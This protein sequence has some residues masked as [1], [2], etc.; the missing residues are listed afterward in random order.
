MHSVLHLQAN[1]SDAKEDQ[2]LEETL[3]ET[4]LGS[5][6]AH[7]HGA[8]L[9]MVPNENDL[10]GAHHDRDETLRLCGLGGLVAENLLKSEVLEAGV[11]SADASCAN[12]VG[13]LKKFALRGILKLLELLLVDVRK[14]SKLFFERDQLLKLLMIW[15]VEVPNLVVES[16][17]VYP[18][19]D[20]LPTLGAQTNHLQAS[21][22]E[23]L[24][25]LIDRDVRRGADQDLAL[26]LPR[27][28]VHDGRARHRFSSAGRPLDEV[29]RALHGLLDGV[30]LGVI[31]LG[32]VGSR[33]MPRKCRS[34]CLSLHIMTQQSVV[35]ETGDARVIDGERPHGSL[36]T[37]EGGRFPDELDTEAVAHVPRTDV[38]GATKLQSDLLVRCDLGD[39]TN[40]APACIFGIAEIGVG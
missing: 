2:T 28:V 36:H 26:I 38:L 32:Q 5:S 37:V 12:H 30:G 22:M 16:E 23:L 1:G 24:G 7:D 33:E 14:L 10:L 3:V 39:V 29:K 18:A 31:Q 8:E 13:G 4:G 15:S 19:G 40:G 9:T 34:H 35:E 27:H 17:V 25:E 20:G 11:A 21:P 6:L